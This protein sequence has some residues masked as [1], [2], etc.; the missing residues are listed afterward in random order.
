[1][2]KITGG[3][4]GTTTLVKFAAKDKKLNEF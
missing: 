1:V 4:D 3:K 2:E